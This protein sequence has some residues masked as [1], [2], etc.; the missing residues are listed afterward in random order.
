[1]FMELT[2]ESH[3]SLPA[4]L[5][6]FTRQET[7]K[8]STNVFYKNQMKYRMSQ[9]RCMAFRSGQY[10]MNFIEIIHC[11]YQIIRYEVEL[12]KSKFKL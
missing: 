9:N 4:V 8:I 3:V 2:R 12:Y 10:Y 6:D 11:K 1:M 7:T 5:V